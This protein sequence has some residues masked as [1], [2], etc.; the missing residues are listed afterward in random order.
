VDWIDLAQ[1]RKHRRALVDKVSKRLGSIECLK[2][3]GGLSGIQ[4][5]VPY[6][7]LGLWLKARPKR[8]REILGLLQIFEIC[9]I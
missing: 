5:A 9:E 8:R 4:N 1:D 2:I 7:K 6:R 3:P